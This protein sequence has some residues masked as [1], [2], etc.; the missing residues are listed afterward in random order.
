M[1]TST[2]KHARCQLHIDDGRGGLDGESRHPVRPRL[3]P[4]SY[5]SQCGME[6]RTLV[7]CTPSLCLLRLRV[8]VLMTV[9]SYLASV[10]NSCS[11]GRQAQAHVVVY[12]HT[13][14]GCIH[15]NSFNNTCIYKMHTK[16]PHAVYYDI[17]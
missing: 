10:A 11:N 9:P 14:L 17:L 16:K 3:C 7:P 15:A 5:S 12:T 6:W 8:C 1:P 13:R 4:S 2:R